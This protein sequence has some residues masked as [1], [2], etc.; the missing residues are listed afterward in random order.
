MSKIIEKFFKY[1]LPC[2]DTFSCFKFADSKILKS[3]TF[4]SLKAKEQPKINICC[5]IFAVLFLI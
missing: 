1:E 3:K 4:E 2:R 5:Y